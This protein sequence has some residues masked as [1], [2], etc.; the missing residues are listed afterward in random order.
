M[1][2]HVN[3]QRV[4]FLVLLS[5][6]PI[7]PE[8]I[9]IL[10]SFTTLAQ[11]HICEGA[12]PSAALMWHRQDGFL[13]TIH[14]M[15]HIQHLAFKSRRQ[16]SILRPPPPTGLPSSGS[17]VRS[18]ALSFAYL[19]PIL[20]SFATAFPSLE[21]LYI[22]TDDLMDPLC[23]TRSQSKV[24]DSVCRTVTPLAESARLLLTTLCSRGMSSTER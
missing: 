14:Q 16:T 1:W 17:H 24:L 2:A 4:V 11:L 23:A 22:D 10:P 19:D 21:K 15:S 20:L 3:D 18:L 12:E 5:S 13:P 8:F 7:L 6:T 9:D